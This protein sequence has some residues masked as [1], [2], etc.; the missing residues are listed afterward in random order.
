MPECRCSAARHRDRN[1][2]F[3]SLK[4][5][6]VLILGLGGGLGCHDPELGAYFGTGRDVHVFSQFLQNKQH[7]ETQMKIYTEFH[8]QTNRRPNSTRNHP[9]HPTE[10]HFLVS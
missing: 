8:Y 4:L 10:H 9:N 3:Q 7:E 5:K 6:E 2:Q 1:I